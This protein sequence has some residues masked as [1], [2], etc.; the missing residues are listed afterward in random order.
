MADVAPR[1]AS[2]TEA[3]MAIL[4]G[5]EDGAPYPPNVG[6]DFPPCG[7]LP[8]NCSCSCRHKQNVFKH[9]IRSGRV[10]HNHRCRLG[11]AYLADDA[12]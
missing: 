6:A 12:P 11:P 2:Q 4:F 3:A 9:T 5:L 7:G 1:A 10:S 8:R